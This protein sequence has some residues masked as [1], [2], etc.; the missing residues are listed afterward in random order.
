MRLLWASTSVKNPALHPTYY[1]DALIGPDTVN[2]VPAPTLDAIFAGVDVARSIDA[3]GEIVQAETLLQEVMS[4]GIDLDALT[5]RLELDGVT[6]FEASY[7]AIIEAL[8]A[9]R[10]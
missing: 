5:D 1:V 9:R 4:H 10:A 6:A 3:P 7:T 8:T 2:T